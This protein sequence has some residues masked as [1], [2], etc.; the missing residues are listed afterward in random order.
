M[1]GI[2]AHLPDAG[3]GNR[4]REMAHVPRHQIIYSV[5]G[6]DGRMS[7]IGG[8]LGREGMRRDQNPAQRNG[9][10]TGADQSGRF[11]RGETGAGFT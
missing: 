10:V 1:T 8:G 6:R 7:G 5:H 11:Q 2:P 3:H 4:I 9:V